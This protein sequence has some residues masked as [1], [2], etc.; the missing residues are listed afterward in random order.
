[1]AA[2]QIMLE[3]DF[4]LVNLYNIVSNSISLKLFK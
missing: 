1:M 2:V 4:N 3:K